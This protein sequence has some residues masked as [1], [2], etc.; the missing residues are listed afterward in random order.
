MPNELGYTAFV[1][2]LGSLVY[3]ELSLWQNR[4]YRPPGAVRTSAE[5]VPV[6]LRK[7][8]VKE[9]IEGLMYGNVEQA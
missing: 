9:K 8:K 1:G 2:A 6:P 5:W 7:G 3:K 4:A